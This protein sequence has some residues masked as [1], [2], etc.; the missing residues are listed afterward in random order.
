MP[1]YG[2]YFASSLERNCPRRHPIDAIWLGRS[3]RQTVGHYPTAS[4]L[5]LPIERSFPPPF[6]RLRV[7]MDRG[8]TGARLA[9]PTGGQHSQGRVENVIE[10]GLLTHLQTPSMVVDRIRLPSVD[11][12]VVPGSTDSSPSKG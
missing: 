1:L 9:I 12:G 5:G 4:E 6:E 2:H 3:A 8:T 7:M 10:K 11:A